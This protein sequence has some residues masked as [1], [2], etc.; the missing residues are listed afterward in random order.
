MP[1]LSDVDAE[2]RHKAAPTV[3]FPEI[4]PW[5]PEFIPLDGRP[6]LAL[7]GVSRRGTRKRIRR[8][9]PIDQ[10]SVRSRTFLN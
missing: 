8:L 2:S 1:R 5:G 7:T 4:H 3:G 9:A 10:G 6:G